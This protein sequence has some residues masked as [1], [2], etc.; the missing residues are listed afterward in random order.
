[1]KSTFCRNNPFFT[2]DKEILRTYDSRFEVPASLK[3]IKNQIDSE[4]PEELLPD[5]SNLKLEEVSKEELCRQ[6]TTR[7][8]EEDSLEEDT[9]EKLKPTLELIRQQC[10]LLKNA[11]YFATQLSSA[12]KCYESLC[13]IYKDF[14]KEVPKVEGIPVLRTEDLKFKTIK[15]YTPGKFNNR[16][17]RKIPIR[18]KQ[19]HSK[20]VSLE[21]FANN[22]DEENQIQESQ[23]SEINLENAKLEEIP[24]EE[25]LSNITSPTYKKPAQ[26]IKV[27]LCSNVNKGFVS[28]ETGEL[29]P[30]VGFGAGYI[31]EYLEAESPASKKKC[32][33]K[34]K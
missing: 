24:K 20:E 29:R 13:T 15:G 28:L 23:S 21:E 7:G 31:E 14:L 16:R 10:D 33:D 19:K 1:M 2:C 4:Q 30:R 27:V 9:N 22:F 5:M 32:V 12:E 3:E 8:T 6:L 18:R 26:R 25:L 17:I 34:G 11:T